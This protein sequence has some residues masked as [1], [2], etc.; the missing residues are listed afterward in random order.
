MRAR[1][2]NKVLCGV[3]GFEGE[4]RARSQWRPLSGS[5][6]AYRNDIA[7]TTALGVI[8]TVRTGVCCWSLQMHIEVTLLVRTT[9]IT[10]TD[11]LRPML[12][13]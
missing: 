3:R 8:S 6:G 12:E 13:I 1:S 2:P 9:F 7:V 5:G 4:I 11:I 10:T